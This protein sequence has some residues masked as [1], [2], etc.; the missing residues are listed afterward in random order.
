MYMR[1]TWQATVVEAELASQAEALER[2]LREAIARLPAWQQGPRL[3]ALEAVIAKR[4][5]RNC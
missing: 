4:K 5:G 1:K 2:L 3:A